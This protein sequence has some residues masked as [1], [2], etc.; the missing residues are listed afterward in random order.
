MKALHLYMSFLAISLLLTSCSSEKKSDGRDFYYR[1]G[2]SQLNRGEEAEA[3]KSFTDSLYKKQN[4][5]AHLKLAVLAEQRGDF[6]ACAYHAD[7]FLQ[8][9]N[10]LWREA[11]RQEARQFKQMAIKALESQGTHSQRAQVLEKMKEERTYLNQKVETL[12]R[13]VIR[14]RNQLAVAKRLPEQPVANSKPVIPTPSKPGNVSL[15]PPVKVVPEKEPEVAS[16]A[17]TIHIVEKGETLIHISKKQ[18]GSGRY[19]RR[20]YEAN[21]AIMPNENSLRIGM[22]LIIPPKPQ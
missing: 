8:D 22:K 21:K 12:G 10:H 7:Q 6:I 13:E 3:I 4:T 9:Q 19:W 16:A 15:T 5:L 11:E 20:I 14:L 1:R 2:I 17:Q 18:Y